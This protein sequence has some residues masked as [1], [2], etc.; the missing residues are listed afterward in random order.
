[1]QAMEV[2]LINSADLFERAAKDIADGQY[3]RAAV[4]LSWLAGFQ[5]VI[6]TVSRIPSLLGNPDSKHSVTIDDSPALE[7]FLEKRNMFGQ[8]LLS[9]DQGKV[10]NLESAMATKSLEDP[11]YQ[12]VKHTQHASQS[13]SIWYR[14]LK[15]V[16]IEVSPP[17]Y[18]EFVVTDKMKEVV[19]ALTLNGDTYFTQFRG[20]HQIPEIL[21]REMNDHL[22]A[23]TAAIQAGNLPKAKRGISAV[24]I[25]FTGMLASLEAITENLAMS[26]Y[27]EIR[28]NLGTTSGSHS[29][30][31][32]DKLF[33]EH[34]NNLWHAV[35]HHIMGS[36]GEPGKYDKL[37]VTD[38][39]KQIYQAAVGDNPNPQTVMDYEL[40]EKCAEFRQNI[41]AWRD[42]HL[43]LPR[44]NLGNDAA[45]LMGAQNAPESA[46][47]MQRIAHAAN[48]DFMAPLAEAR[49]DSTTLFAMKETSNRSVRSL[50][51]D[52]LQRMGGK[53]TQKRFPNVQDRAYGKSS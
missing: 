8:T 40:L 43:N 23:S 12:I 14:H 47:N 22:V 33:T 2:G 34:Y 11:I 24:N 37:V 17:S 32:R 6:E 49:G 13:A 29:K 38:R 25:L 20:L 48:R 18:P 28:E 31:I 16:G 3:G 41:I 26:D 36:S 44:N 15:R 53:I 9:A 45:S 21:A 51:D 19:F 46:H 42:N 35:E 4:K 30:A 1:M 10:I 5:K 7:S 52:E 50:L 27:H 39:I